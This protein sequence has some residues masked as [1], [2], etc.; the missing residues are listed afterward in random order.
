MNPLNFYKMS[1]AGNDFILIDNRGKVVDELTLREMIIGI[2]RHKLSVGADGVIL[3]ENS[4]TVDFA[5]RF[6][7]ADGSTAE[8]CGNG[9]RCAAR[10]AVM[11]EIAGNDLRFE[12]LAGVIQARVSAEGLVKIRLTD[13]SAPRLQLSVSLSTGIQ[14]V[15]AI[16][17]GVPHIVIETTDI[18]NTKVVEIGREIRN[19]NDFS[20]AGTNVNFVSFHEDGYLS[21]R[22]YERGVENETL[23]CGT[24]S[25]AAALVMS[26]LH[27]LPSPVRIRTESGAFLNIYFTQ[28]AD[29]RFSD[30][31]LEGDARLIYTAQLNDEA[32]K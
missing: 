10:L 19:H 16:N 17:T 11:L 32:W 14:T 22:T 7:N 30:L 27:Q 4:P 26:A 20:P 6:F 18:R 13:P 29:G 8:M 2:C 25:T 3:I 24:G 28:N 9:A 15:H 1:G 5:W 12:T 23:A 31:F 21:V